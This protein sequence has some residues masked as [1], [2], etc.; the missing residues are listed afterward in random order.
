M[1]AANV[2]RARA[3]ARVVT[4]QSLVTLVVDGVVD[5]L[6]PWRLQR[7]SPRAPDP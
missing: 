3:L 5:G 2:R 1:P 4:R 6:H 7:H